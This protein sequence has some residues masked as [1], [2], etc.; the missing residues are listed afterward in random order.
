MNLNIT[1]K[2]IC[3]FHPYLKRLQVKGFVLTIYTIVYGLKKFSRVLA[4][5][6][7]SSGKCTIV[8]ALNNDTDG[9]LN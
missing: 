2:W 3:P 5:G 8:D 4:R 7:M 6:R 1:E 9:N